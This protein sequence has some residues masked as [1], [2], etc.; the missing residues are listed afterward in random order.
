MQRVAADAKKSAAP[1]ADGPKPD[2]EGKK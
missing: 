2:A 1:K